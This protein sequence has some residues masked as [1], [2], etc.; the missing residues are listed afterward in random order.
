MSNR[1]LE[2]WFEFASTYSYLSVMRVEEAA[3]SAGVSVVWKP[4]LLGPIFHSQGWQTSPYIIYPAKGRY[5][6]RDME[7]LCAKAELAFQL[8]LTIPAYSVTAARIALVA[9]DEAWGVDFVKAVFQAEFAQGKD[10]ADNAVL[11]AILVDM[12]Q[13]ADTVFE[14]ALTDVNKER[15]KNQTEEVKT[16]DIFGAPMFVTGDG[17]LFWG[18]DR[19]DLAMAAASG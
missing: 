9:L 5:M 8:P 3:A 10:I 7:R 14:K 2:F 19:L 1:R 13:D 15:L 11:Q 17:D 18:D 6:V 4:F 12:G 16:K